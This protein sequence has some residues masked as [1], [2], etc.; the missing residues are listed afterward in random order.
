M[1]ANDNAIILIAVCN[2]SPRPEP[3]AVT[4][5]KPKLDVSITFIDTCSYMFSE[6]KKYIVHH[7]Q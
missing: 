5:K 4:S 1:I 7:Y 2:L 3:E 6:I